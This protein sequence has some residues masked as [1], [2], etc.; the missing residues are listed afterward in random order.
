MLA[1]HLTLR[2]RLCTVI[3]LAPNLFRTITKT[4]TLGGDLSTLN[5]SCEVTMD[6][7][8]LGNVMAD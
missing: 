1:V 8:H 7:G 6:F 3:K 2:I 4:L 5:P